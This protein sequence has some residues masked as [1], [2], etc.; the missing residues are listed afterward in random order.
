[1]PFTSVS[2]IVIDSTD[3]AMYWGFAPFVCRFVEADDFEEA[4][5]FGIVMRKVGVTFACVPLPPG[6]GLGD[7]V[8]FVDWFPPLPF[9][10]DEPPPP[11]PQA[12][13][14]RTAASARYFH[15]KI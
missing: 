1:V 7:G 12:V 11:P 13:N 15:M 2:V 4:I 9:G 14:P 6:E 10:T 3:G 8:G 5:T